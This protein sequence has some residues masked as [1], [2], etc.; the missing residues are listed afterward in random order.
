ML[1]RQLEAALLNSHFFRQEGNGG[2]Q[3]RL[4]EPNSKQANEN[5][6]IISRCR[7]STKILA[8]VGAFVCS[9]EWGIN[10]MLGH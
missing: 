10:E 1:V 5:H 7:L 6:C 8:S 3:H 4:A 2:L 9:V